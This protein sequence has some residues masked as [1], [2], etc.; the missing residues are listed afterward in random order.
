MVWRGFGIN[1]CGLVS[2]IVLDDSHATAPTF[3]AK[4]YR[5]KHGTINAY[6]TKLP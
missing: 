2:L 4:I 5:G 3:S 6:K 1:R